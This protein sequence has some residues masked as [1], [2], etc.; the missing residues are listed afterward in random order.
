MNDGSR[1]PVA[2]YVDDDLFVSF[3]TD[4][5]LALETMHKTRLQS[6]IFGAAQ[7]YCINQLSGR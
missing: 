7:S 3:E 2:A 5:K 6:A 1:L 4:L